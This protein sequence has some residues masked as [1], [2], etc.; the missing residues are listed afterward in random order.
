MLGRFISFLGTTRAIFFGILLG[1]LIGFLVGPSAEAL[2]PVGTIFISLLK[3]VVIPLVFVSI[4]LG[5]YQTGTLARLGTIGV[6]TSVYYLSTTFLAVALGMVLVTIARPGAGVQLESPGFQP[7]VEAIDSLLGFLTRLVPDNIFTAFAEMNILGIIL[8]AIA[9]GVSLLFTGDRGKPL[10][11]VLTSLNDV[12]LTL[13]RGII[14]VAPI[15]VIGLLAP[16]IGTF[17]F[18][19]LAP[20]WKFVLVVLGGLL[21]HAVVVL[22]FIFKL[23][24]NRPLFGY[25]GSVRR[26][27]LTAFAT[28]S[29][30][31]TLP[32][33]LE[34]AR[35]GGIKDETSGFVL[36]LGAT[37]NM[38]GTALYEG[39]VAIFIA[40]SLGLDLTV[41]QQFT[42]F[43]TATLA[44]IGAPGIPSAGLVTI[45]LVLQAVGLPAVGIGILFAIDRPLDMCRTT[46]NVWGDLVGCAVVEGKIKN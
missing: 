45:L 2:K 46:V 33:T 17:G 9:V 21:L 36:P 14:R 44:S 3:L 40:Q 23:F 19:I 8:F 25:V 16:L 4:V 30:S 28:A 20:F 31:A 38:D 11:L 29:S 12:F 32:V 15:G 39:V 6:R 34:S 37:V 7:E 35:G 1:A 43:L 18:S 22:P 27:L 42:I 26:A 41:G 13:T 24:S 5:V 10:V